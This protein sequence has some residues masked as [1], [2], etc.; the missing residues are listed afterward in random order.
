MQTILI[1]FLPALITMALMSI[2]FAIYGI[3]VEP[4]AKAYCKR[5]GLDWDG[6]NETDAD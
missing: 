2:S 1:R 5:K 3:F 6:D 4:L